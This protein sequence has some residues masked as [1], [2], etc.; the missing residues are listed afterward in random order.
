MLQPFCVSEVTLALCYSPFC[1]DLCDWWLGLSIF[2]YACLTQ[3]H[4][5]SSTTRSSQIQCL[6]NPICKDSQNRTPQAW[7]NWDLKATGKADTTFKWALKLFDT[8]NDQQSLEAW[9][10]M[11]KPYPQPQIHFQGT[12]MQRLRSWH[13]DKLRQRL[14]ADSIGIAGGAASPASPAQKPCQINDSNEEFEQKEMIS[15]KWTTTLFHEK[16]RTRNQWPSG[17]LIS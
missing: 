17:R 3:K 13:N 12:A 6:E 10:N 2:V 8:E 7:Q 5:P 4:G 16:T 15:V 1:T 14:W 11:E 9:K